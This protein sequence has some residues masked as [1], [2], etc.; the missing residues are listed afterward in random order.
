MELHAPYAFYQWIAT[1]ISYSEQLLFV[2]FSFR[3][4][5]T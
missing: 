1:E 2:V 4:R 3:K 5:K